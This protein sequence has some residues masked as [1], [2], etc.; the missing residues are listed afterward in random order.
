[1]LIVGC[2]GIGVDCRVLWCRISPSGLEC[3][4]MWVVVH[5]WS[6]KLASVVAAV[7]FVGS[8][9]MRPTLMV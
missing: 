9:V 8:E 7:A 4:Y 1:V 5:W 3:C 6:C 2:S